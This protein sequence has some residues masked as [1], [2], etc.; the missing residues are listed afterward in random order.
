MIARSPAS[1][2]S[3]ATAWYA[4][5]VDGA[6]IGDSELGARPRLAQPVGAVDDGVGEIRVDLAPGLI[7]RPGRQPERDGLAVL[8]LDLLKGPAQQDRQLVGIGRF[9][10]GEP[11]LRQPGQRLADRLMRA[12]FGCQRDPRRGRD[13]DEPRI[14]IACIVQRIVPALVGAC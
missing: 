6:A 3:S 9:E 2:M 5:I 11:R 7:E 4:A 14:L 10:G 8:A 13:Q 1:G 12:A